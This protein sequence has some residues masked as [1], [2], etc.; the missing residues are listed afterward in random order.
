[1]NKNR[2]L[3]IFIWLFVA[4]LLIIR[5]EE[6]KAYAKHEEETLCYKQLIEENKT[7]EECLKYYV[8]KK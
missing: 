3:I 7:S 1:M 4:I 8:C 2:M 5:L 6:K